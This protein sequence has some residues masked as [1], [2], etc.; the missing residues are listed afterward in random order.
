MATKQTVKPTQRGVVTGRTPAQDP[1]ENKA[2]TREIAEVKKSTAV[3]I[4]DDVRAMMEQDSGVGVSTDA[5]DNIVP[6]L[7]L[8]QAQSPQ[9]L[10][11]KQ[12]CIKP[13]VNGNKT[14]VAGNIW[15]RGSKTLI[16]GETD[17]LLV[18]LCH[19]RKAWVEWRPERGGYAGEHAT[20]PDIAEWIEDPKKPGK[21]KW[22]LPSGNVVVETRY[23]VV[24]VHDEAIAGGAPTPFV[25]PMSSTNHTA[26]RQWM[27]DIGRKRVPGTDKRASLWAYMWRMTTIPKSNDDGDWY[28]WAIEDGGPE[29]EELLCSDVA[30]YKIA[31]QLHEDFEKGV[32]H[33]DTPEEEVV[34]DGDGR[35]HPDDDKN[36]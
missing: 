12:E 2:P 26:A 36:I 29:G 6:L 22:T 3:A 31:R 7:Y 32:K 33:A 13:G 19:F 30:A 28:G 8:L 35:G 16:D 9:C 25:I 17:G 1:K 18:Q 27:T 20:R 5:A 21:G 14:A 24:L 4:A 11:Q 10:A 34:D 15:P 23:H